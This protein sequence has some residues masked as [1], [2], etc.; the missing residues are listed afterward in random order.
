MPQSRGKIIIA[1]NRML[2]M[3]V[4]RLDFRYV[5]KIRFIGLHVQWGEKE[6][7]MKPRLLAA[8]SFILVTN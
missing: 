2:G 5:L 6:N 4:R 3:E 7:M 1:W 8:S